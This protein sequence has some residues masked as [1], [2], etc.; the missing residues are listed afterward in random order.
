M[1]MTVYRKKKKRW[2]IITSMSPILEDIKYALSSY[3]LTPN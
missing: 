1:N 2:M 3:E